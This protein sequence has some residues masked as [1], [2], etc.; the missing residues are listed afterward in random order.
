[1]LLEFFLGNKEERTAEETVKRLADRKDLNQR[2]Q[3]QLAYARGLSRRLFLKRAVAVASVGL[4]VT[5]GG[6]LLLG[7]GQA[8]VNTSNFDWLRI[9]DPDRM[10]ISRAQEAAK[11]AID[12]DNLYQAGRDIT[13]KPTDSS[14]DFDERA[15]PGIIYLVPR[16]DP[17]KN[18]LHAMTHAFK[19]DK[20]TF[21]E[22][23][24]PYFDGSIRG[25]HGLA[26][27]LSTNSKG[28]TMFTW[29]EEGMAERN[30]LAFPG[31]TAPNIRYNNVGK[32]TLQTFPLQSSQAHELVRGNNVPEFVNSILKLP[33]SHKVTGEDFTE[34]MGRYAEAFSNPKSL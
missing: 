19:P 12:W 1:M 10:G 34:V 8:P 7:N 24:I 25:Y 29:L 2:Q 32:L 22:Q 15:E 14:P 13:I 18:V 17:R 30:A 11:A 31:Y 5:E 20:P 27:L 33:S 28:S 4:V 23:P 16:A 21:L 6:I 3:E 9:D 26:L